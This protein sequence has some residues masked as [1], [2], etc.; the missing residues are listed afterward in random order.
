MV[1][2]RI[3]IDHPRIT[4]ETG[5]VVFPICTQEHTMRISQRRHGV[6]WTLRLSL[7][8][9]TFPFAKVDRHTLPMIVEE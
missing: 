1:V 2:E 3:A 4:H 6:A 7:R 8:E 9:H 5:S